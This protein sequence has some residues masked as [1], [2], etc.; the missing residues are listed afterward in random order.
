MPLSVSAAYIRKYFN[1][2]SKKAVETMTNSIHKEFIKMLEKVPWMDE[3]TRKAAIE[4]AKAMTFHI[5]YPNEL[6]DDDKLNEHFQD[7]KL[8]SD[9]QLQNILRI[10]QFR[11]KDIIDELRNRLDKDDWRNLGTGIT[12]VNAFYSSIDNT[13]QMP[14]A[15][16]QGRFFSAER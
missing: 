16:L 9:S 5:G 4:K 8:K 12:H 10:E 14:A 3:T 15:I 7:L 1:E 2:D 6:M 13:I 11:N